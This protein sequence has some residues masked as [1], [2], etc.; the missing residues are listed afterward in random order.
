MKQAIKKFSFVILASVLSA[1]AV[2]FAQD[3]EK[4]KSDKKD[5]E[6]IIITRKANSDEKMVIEL[7]GDKV[8]VN[9]KPVDKDNADV[10][11]HRAKIK[12]VYAYDGSGFSGSWNDNFA[13]HD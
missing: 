9:G 11:V 3:K 5:S 2:S 8:T 1:P 7:N 6:Q 4:E 13:L 12:D 10:K